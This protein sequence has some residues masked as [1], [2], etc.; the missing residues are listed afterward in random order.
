[1]EEKKTRELSPEEMEKVS[2]GSNRFSEITVSASDPEPSPNP[3]PDEKHRR[4]FD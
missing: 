4:R 2:G 1:M 3:D